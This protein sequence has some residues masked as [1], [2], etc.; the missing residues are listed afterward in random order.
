MR[1]VGLEK[2]GGG[3]FIAGMQGVPRTGE[4]QEVHRLATSGTGLMA[5]M[6]LEFSLLLSWCNFFL[7]FFH[8]MGDGDISVVILGYSLT[9]H[10]PRAKV[11]LSFLDSGWKISDQEADWCFPGGSVVKNLPTSVGDT[12]EIPDLGRSHRLWSNSARVPQILSLCSRAQELQLLKPSPLKPMLP[13]K[14][15]HHNEKPVCCNL[16]KACAVTQHSHKQIKLF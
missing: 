15:S 13:N 5:L 4:V 3:G 14:R 2:M 8:G 11:E 16:K 6:S 10:D 12:G 9:S 7:S 1:K